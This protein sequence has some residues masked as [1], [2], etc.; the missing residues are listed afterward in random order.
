MLVW[1]LLLSAPALERSRFGWKL[2]DNPDGFCAGANGRNRMSDRMKL[3]LASLSDKMLPYRLGLP[4]S[5][6]VVTAIVATAVSL[7]RGLK[8]R[9]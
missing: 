2:C 7:Y 6:V 9:P 5:V 3:A 1:P 4:L 8:S